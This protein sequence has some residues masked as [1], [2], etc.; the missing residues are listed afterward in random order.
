MMNE[1]Y[2]AEIDVECQWITNENII[3]YD[4]KVNWNP[5]LYVEN[6]LT[7]TKQTIEYKVSENADYPGS[8]VITEYRKIK[9]VI[10]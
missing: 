8:K 1:K 3:N 4:P 2:M 10:Y 6:L 9:G 7:E 5:C